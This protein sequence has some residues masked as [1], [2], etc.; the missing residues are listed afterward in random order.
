M[1]V[2]VADDLSGAAELAG[3]AANAGL[4]AEVV[5]W[6]FDGFFEECH[7]SVLAVDGDTRGMREVDAVARMQEIGAWVRERQPEWVF[8][9]VD[10]VLRG[11]V[12]AEGEALR[13]A[14]E[15]DQVLLVPANPSKGRVI[16]GGRYW[17]NE[18]LLEET[19]FANDPDFPRCSSAV[20]ELV[21]AAPVT[22]AMPDVESMAEVERLAG[23]MDR[24]TTL[25]VGAAD[26]FAALLGRIRQGGEEP[27]GGCESA[28]LTPALSS[29]G[30]GDVP[31][32]S[33]EPVRLFLC[34][35]AAAW[36]GRE[37]EARKNRIW[38]SV[39]DDDVFGEA[40][41]MVLMGLGAM[42]VANVPSGELATR[43]AARARAWMAMHPEGG[44]IFAEGGATGAALARRCG[45]GRFHVAPGAPVGIAKLSPVDEP[46]WTMWLKPG[47]YPWP[48]ELG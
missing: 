37:R 39:S 46:R 36:P 26:F 12:R 47:S 25:G 31:A 27:N 7:S 30:E 40:D 15:L 17:V 3:I 9:K 44:V 41:Q 33:G 11:H 21:G 1:I 24:R 32:V 4:L 29:G 23:A 34:G 14:L 35:S 28:L 6:P 18:V 42:R 10:S 45:W 8:K 5:T 19:V 2:V 48:F 20:D 43:L 22:W 13:S 16:R 38:V